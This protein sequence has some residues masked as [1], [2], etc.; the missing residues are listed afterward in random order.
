MAWKAAVAWEAREE[1]PSPPAA[2]RP[3]E[4]LA[5]QDHMAAAKS[6]AELLRTVDGQARGELRLVLKWLCREEDLRWAAPRVRR[7]LTDTARSLEGL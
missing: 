7:F 5:F 3:C 2:S 6:L 4:L 1:Q